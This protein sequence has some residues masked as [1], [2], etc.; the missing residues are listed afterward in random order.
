MGAA[1]AY[2]LGHSQIGTAMR[3]AGLFAAG[4]IPFMLQNVGGTITLA[5]TTHMMAA[6][7]SATFH[8]ISATETWKSDVVNE[9]LEPINGLVPVPEQPGLGLTLD[10]EA[11]ERLKSIER[12]KPE[13][14]IIKSRFKNGAR[15]YGLVDPQDRLFLV[16][17]DRSRLL[18]MRYAEPLATEYWDDDGT[19]EYATMLA[20]LEQSGMV[21]ER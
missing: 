15:L 16:R 14:W 6:F 7:P 19:A 9:R 18:P 10:R 8:T 5:M 21:L 20:R 2:M 13:R 4:N 3:R 11:L 12:P 17:P 1:D